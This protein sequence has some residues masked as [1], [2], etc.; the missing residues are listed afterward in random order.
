[1]L[2]N[3]FLARLGALLDQLKRSKSSRSMGAL[4]DQLKR[5]KNNIFLARLGAL[6]DSFSCLLCQKI[7]NWGDQPK[8]HY[9]SHA[10]LFR[11]FLAG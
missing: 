8:V 1:M 9:T 4:L 6:L 7:F 11:V 2:N 10:L 3:Y 5:S